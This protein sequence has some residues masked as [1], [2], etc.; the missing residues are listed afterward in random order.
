LTSDLIAALSCTFEYDE[1][2]N[3]IRTIDA[4]GNDT[5]FIVNELNQVVRRKSREVSDSSGVR[6]ERDYY[7][8]ENNNI[9]QVDV[10][11]KD[12]EGVLED[13]T[14]FTTNYEYNILNYPSRV[15]S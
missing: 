2:G 6:Y 12:E 14:Y 13:N 11:N 3:L 5:Q 15:T 1:V 7:Y 8:D 4:R 10:Q 9:V